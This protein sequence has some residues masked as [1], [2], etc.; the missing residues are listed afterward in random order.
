[1]PRSIEYNAWSR[2]G[3]RHPHSLIESSMLHMTNRSGWGRI[4][5]E[6]IFPWCAGNRSRQI[7]SWRFHVDI[8]LSLLN[9]S[10]V[11]PTF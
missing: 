3:C 11:Q 4:E 8:G 1:M 6:T 2:S 7:R 5:I 10:I 9:S